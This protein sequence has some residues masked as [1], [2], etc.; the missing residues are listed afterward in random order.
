MKE[1]QSA[2]QFT[3]GN[4]GVTMHPMQEYEYVFGTTDLAESKP[5]T[6]P[7]IGDKAKYEQTE[8]K[9]TYLSSVAARVLEPDIP[10]LREYRPLEDILANPP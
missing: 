10:D 3:T 7:A 4:Y 1:H 8:K 2:M 9:M 6:L 5:P